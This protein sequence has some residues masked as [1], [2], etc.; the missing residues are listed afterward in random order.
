[1][2]YNQSMLTGSGTLTT[3]QNAR[4]RA[5]F[6]ESVTPLD[7]EEDSCFLIV[8]DDYD[9]PRPN[10]E[11]DAHVWV[12]CDS[13]EA[14]FV[15]ILDA[16]RESLFGRMNRWGDRIRQIPDPSQEPSPLDQRP[17]LPPGED[18]AWLRSQLEDKK[19]EDFTD[20][21][22]AAPALQARRYG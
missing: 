20:I 6:C 5:I 12:P 15:R 14:R 22:G 3:V 9:P 11:D 13:A 10:G 16:T 4:E 19:K 1:M 8:G 21:E 2:G 7:L 18:D 17:P